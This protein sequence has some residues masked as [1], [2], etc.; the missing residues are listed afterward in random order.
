M[1]SVVMIK[2]DSIHLVLKELLPICQVKSDCKN[3]AHKSP[4]PKK[5]CHLKHCARKSAPGAL[6][7]GFQYQG[8]TQ[9][10]PLQFPLQFPSLKARISLGIV[11][12]LVL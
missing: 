1:E 2:K 5:H 10:D 3:E 6:D 8:L 11:A 7:A 4:P 9:Q 12:T